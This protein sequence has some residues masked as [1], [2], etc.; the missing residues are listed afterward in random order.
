MG[1]YRVLPVV[2]AAGLVTGCPNDPMGPE[3]RFA[4]IALGQCKYDTA[5]KLVDDAIAS[6][7]ENY[8]E[9]GLML[10]AAILRDRG[11]TGAA[12]AL[13][14]EIA[15]AWKARKGSD[16]KDSR[17]ERDIGLYLDAARGERRANGLP[18]DCADID[19][20]TPR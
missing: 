7:D 13:Y 1:L 10:K 2:L 3:V 18:E 20:P 9:R 17:R 5:L 19:V 14:P 16:L 15:A 12:T 11:D 6:D 8:R 4:L